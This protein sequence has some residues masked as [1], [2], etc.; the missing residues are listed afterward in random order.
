MHMV[1]K[2]TVI[3]A[4]NIRIKLHIAIDIITVFIEP[5][6]AWENGYNDRIANASLL[7]IISW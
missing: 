3:Y 6:R 5:N 2:A 7:L 1:S 4:K